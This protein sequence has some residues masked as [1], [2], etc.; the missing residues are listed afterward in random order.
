MIEIRKVYPRL[1]NLSDTA[2]ILLVGENLGAVDESHRKTKREFVKAG[3]ADNAF[4]S[5]YKKYHLLDKKEKE[6]KV[7]FKYDRGFRIDTDHDLYVALRRE[8]QGLYTH[9]TTDSAARTVV[10]ETLSLPS[11]NLGIIK[12]E[13]ESGTIHYQRDKYSKV[14]SALGNQNL[15]NEEYDY[16]WMG[17]RNVPH[18]YWLSKFALKLLSIAR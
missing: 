11:N 12:K 16:C 10:A 17:F 8:R 4:Y 6:L 2:D 7:Y 14:V 1:R 18:H 3:A 13:L 15:F 9:L 5:A